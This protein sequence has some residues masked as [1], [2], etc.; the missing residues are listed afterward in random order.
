MAE[1]VYRKLQKYFD[2]FPLRFPE[3]ESGVEIRLLKT[4]F[5]PEEAEI[6][7]K[8][9][10]SPRDSFESFDSLETIFERVKHLGYTIKK[11]E[12]YLD[13]MAK[14]GAIMGVT[15]NNKKV[16]AN[17]LFI[18]GIFEYQVN[19]LRKEFVVEMTQY[20]QEAWG[21]EKEVAF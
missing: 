8:I 13:G 10:F 15:Y 18:I 6:A 20:L 2:G 9:S 14:K 19:K 21:Q 12:E 5:T 1:D 17:S 11:V 7:S 4:L 3:T 16:Y